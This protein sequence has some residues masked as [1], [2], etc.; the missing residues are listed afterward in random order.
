MGQET[1]KKHIAVILDSS[2]K[3]KYFGK[4]KFVDENELNRL[5]NESSQIDSEKQ[6]KKAELGETINELKEK[7]NLLETQVKQLK[8]E[9]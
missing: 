5:K 7:I 6:R 2:G 3:C 9:E 1:R 8:G 4:V